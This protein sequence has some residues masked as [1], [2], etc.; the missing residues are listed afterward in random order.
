MNV[1]LYKHP[2]LLLHCHKTAKFTWFTTLRF[3]SFWPT[4]PVC[5]QA[6]LSRLVYTLINSRCETTRNGLSER[7]YRE[8]LMTVTHWCVHQSRLWFYLLTCS[9]LHQWQTGQDESVEVNQRALIDKVLARYSGEF[10]GE[11]SWDRS[12]RVLFQPHT[13]DVSIPGAPPEL[14]RCSVVRSRDS[15]RDCCIPPS[16]RQ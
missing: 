14:G 16:E 3:N 5:Q 2:P 6:D 4:T 9:Y 8:W 10:T 1:P 11:R 7:T 12:V 13:L 15:L